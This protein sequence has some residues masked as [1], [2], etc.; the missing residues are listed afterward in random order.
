MVKWSW[1]WWRV[2]VITATWEV[3][4]GGSPVWGQP[5]QNKTYLKNK[6]QAGHV[7]HTCNLIFSEGRNQEDCD[8]RPTWVSNFCN[9]QKFRENQSQQISWVWCSI[10]VILAMG[11]GIIRRIT[12]QRWPRQKHQT[13]SEKITKKQNRLGI[14]FK[15]L[16]S[17]HST[18]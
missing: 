1:V 13:L 10:L 5:R 15:T 2:P 17:N 18:T 7:V 16:S 3:D 4:S 14:W 9:L 8:W 11:R 6:I 12:V